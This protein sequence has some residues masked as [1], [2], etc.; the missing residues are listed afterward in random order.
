MAK[1]KTTL[2]IDE[3]LLRMAKVRAAR[4]DRRESEV[5]EAALRSYLGITA[6]EQIR[7]RSDLDEA[8][9]MELAYAELRAMRRGG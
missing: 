7:A 9:A 2:Y 1:R 6:L 8:Q 5:M 4:T 3:E